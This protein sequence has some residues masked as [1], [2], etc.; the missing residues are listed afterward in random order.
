MWQPIAAKYTNMGKAGRGAEPTFSLANSCA[1]TMAAA[2]LY[3][4]SAG[5]L[6]HSEVQ[7]QIT[8][9]VAYTSRHTKDI[10]DSAIGVIV[11]H[12]VYREK[13]LPE[14]SPRSMHFAVY[15]LLLKRAAQNLVKVPNFCNHTFISFAFH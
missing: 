15:I 7:R 12:N 8:G 6:Q 13:C 14:M 9:Q 1:A 2:C 10:T 3:N 5:V 11:K 4:Q